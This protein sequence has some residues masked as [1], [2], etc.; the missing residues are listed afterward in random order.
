MKRVAIVG[1][2][3]E[4]STKGKLNAYRREG[5]IPGVLYGKIVDT[6][7]VAVNEKEF[8]KLEKSAG[9]SA[10]YD[11]TIQ[12][13][14][15]PTIIKEIQIDPIKRNIIHID[16]EA[17]DLEKPVYTSIPV[18]TVGEAKGVKKGGILDQ[19]IHEIEVEGLLTDLPDRVEVDVSNLD[20]KDVIYVKDLKLGDK[21]KIYSDP[22][23]VVV[24]VVTPT[25]EEV[26]APQPEA[27][28]E[29][30]PQEVAKETKPGESKET[31]EK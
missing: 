12:G 24:S 11:L 21:I 17:V 30:Q 31:K 13:K 6:Y 29:A 23:G 5:K 10:I 22:D 20:I 9:R 18:V 26:P 3:R 15:Y 16:F 14:S 4:V 7:Y 27:A 25:V 2:E 8:L 1:E 28:V 19:T